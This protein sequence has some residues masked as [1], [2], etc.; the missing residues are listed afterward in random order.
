MAQFAGQHRL[1]VVD[2]MML[3]T[4]RPPKKGELVL[5]VSGDPALLDRLTPV[6]QAIDSRTIN[7]GERLGQATPAGHP[8][9]FVLWPFGWN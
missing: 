3:G 8:N 4:R 2:A 7:A 5:L 9:P 6:F 1:Q